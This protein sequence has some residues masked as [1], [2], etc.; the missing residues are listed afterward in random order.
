MKAVVISH[1]GGPEVLQLRDY[2]QPDVVADEV[3]IAVKAAGL[4]HSDIF[5]RKGNY[6]PPEGASADIPG[7]EVAGVIVACGPE[8]SQWKSGDQVCA[9]V[10]GGGYAEFVNVREGQC[11]PLPEGMSYT[12]AAALPEAVFTVWS[13]IF[14]RGALK[15][16]E[17]L[18]IHGGSSG[19]GTTAIQIAHALK[20]KVFVTAGSDEKGRKCLELGADRFVNH[21]TQDFE[22]ILIEE[23][24]D[25]ILE[26]VG[27]DYLVKNCNILRPEG[28]LIYINAIAGDTPPI[29][30]RQIM[31]KRLTITG[32]MLR[33][34]DY[35]FKKRLAKSVQM[36]VWPLI[37]MG[38]FH[39]LI[40]KTFPLS[41]AAEAHKLLETSQHIGKIVL[42][43]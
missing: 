11:L 29:R 35:T 3:L 8:V 23:G 2:P 9:L 34:R 26:M 37:E 27:G 30:I 22:K 5:Q 20:A 18:L 17:N 28:R 32:S 33:N 42:T 25:V 36:R 13:N 24:M 15:P 38:K 1:A 10:A 43:I 19:I 41:D 4:N 16:G 40:Y 14:E 7:L 12:A 31:S 21:K 6:P 39:P